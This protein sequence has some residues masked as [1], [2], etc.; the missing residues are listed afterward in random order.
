MNPRNGA[1]RILTVQI[2]LPAEN[3]RLIIFAIGTATNAPMVICPMFIGTSAIAITC[4]LKS[5]PRKN[6]SYM[7]YPR[8]MVS[9]P[10]ATENIVHPSCGSAV[11]PTREISKAANPP[12]T[13]HTSLGNVNVYDVNPRVSSLSPL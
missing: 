5:H 4:I 11:K 7:K 8:T 3:M 9:P 13:S 2:L 10:R 6:I 12:K 1:L